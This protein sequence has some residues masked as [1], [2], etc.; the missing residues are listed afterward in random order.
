[1]GIKSLLAFFGT[2]D[3]NAVIDKPFHD[4]GRFVIAVTHPVK[5]EYKMSKA[6]SAASRWISCMASRCLADALK[7]ET[8]F[9]E[10]SRTMSQ[11][12]CAANS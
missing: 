3:L 8:P 12:I 5:H 10:N 1:M 6:F 2:P 7:P 11:P 9:S 4:E